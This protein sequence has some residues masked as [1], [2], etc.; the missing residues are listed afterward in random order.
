[1]KKYF[2]WKK[3]SMFAIVLSLLAALTVP[4]LAKAP[5]K[6]AD[7]FYNVRGTISAVDVTAGTVTVQ[8]KLAS[9]LAKSYINKNL[10]V[11]T[12]SSTVFR[13]YAKNHTSSRKIKI[14]QLV[15]G[16]TI[17]V[18][19]KL[20]SGVYTATTIREGIALPE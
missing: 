8:V 16:R 12:T 3:L 14:D 4:A 2:I 20:I 13:H 10:V 6:K 9:P 11:T 1:M 18:V 15:V 19:G 5:Q 17:R 7:N